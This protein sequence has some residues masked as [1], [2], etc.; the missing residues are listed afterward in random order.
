MK[1]K[2]LQPVGLLAAALISSNASSI[3]AAEIQTSEPVPEKLQKLSE[4]QS[5]PIW[6]L[7]Q[8]FIIRPAK[9][10]STTLLAHSSHASHASHSSH[11]SHSS[12][13][14]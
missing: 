1:K 3:D 9:A 6:N 2:F 7:E 12:S 10:N 4:E 11:S 5:S 14:Y 13:G 8:D